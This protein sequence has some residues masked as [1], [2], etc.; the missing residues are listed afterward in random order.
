MNDL[1]TSASPTAPSP[2]GPQTPAA[3][4]DAPTPVEPQAGQAPQAPSQNTGIPNGVQA[5]SVIPAQAPPA[6]PPAVDYSNIDYSKVDWSKVKLT[7]IPKF[8]EWQSNADRQA[9]QRARELEQK[10]R[11]DIQNMQTQFQQ[12]LN[13]VQQQFSQFVPEDQRLQMQLAQ[14]QY[15][16]D[17]MA[18]Q[19]NQFQQQQANQMVLMDMADNYGVPYAELAQQGFQNPFDAEKHIL[20]SRLEAQTEENNDLMKRLEKLE[21]TVT[22]AQAESVD[23]PDLGGGLPVNNQQVYQQQYDDYLRKGQ[24]YMAMQ[25]SQQAQGEGIKLDTR[26]LQVR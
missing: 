1:V 13:G 22:A 26:P 17:M 16:Q 10:Y 5:D 20:N 6:T 14:S 12:Q 8:K 9:S 7:D 25:V 18:Q 19:L 23:N 15:Q 11:S 2:G 4:S 3:P 21:Q 24:S